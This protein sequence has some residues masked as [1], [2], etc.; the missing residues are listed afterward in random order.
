MKSPDVV[1]APATKKTSGKRGRGKKSTCTKARI[2]A[3]ELVSAKD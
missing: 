3:Q 2:S 1:A